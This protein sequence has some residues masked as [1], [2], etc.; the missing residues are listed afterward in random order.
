M[1]KPRAILLLTLY[2]AISIEGC[3]DSAGKSLCEAVPVPAPFPEKVSID[4][5]PERI[6]YD[7]GGLKV[8]Q[9][10]A[11]T[12]EALQAACGM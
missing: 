8:L 7:D 11:A 2:A 9:E 6:L 10:Y 3:A 1:K 12:R 5:S 4:I